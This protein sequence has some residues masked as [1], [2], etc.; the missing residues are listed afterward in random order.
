MN[1]FS[2]NLKLLGTSDCISHKNSSRPSS[3]WMPRNKM[4]LSTEGNYWC[5]RLLTRVAV[6][7][8]KC[9]TLL[10]LGNFHI[11]LADVASFPFEIPWDGRLPA[12]MD[13]GPRILDQPAGKHGH[14]IAK[15]DRLIFEDGVSQRFWGVGLTFSSGTKTL[16]PPDKIV[17]KKIV[18]KLAQ[19]GFNHVRFVGLDGTAP[20]ITDAWLRTGK[21]DSPTLDKLD[22]FIDLLRKEGIYYSFAIN[23]GAVRVLSGVSSIPGK[24]FGPDF[25]R[26]RHVRLL[27]DT[28]IA[29]QV[30]W[31]QAFFS[32]VNPYTGLSYAQDPANLYVS[33]M[34]EDSASLAYFN[35]YDKLGE[36]AK[37]LF[38]LRYRNFLETGLVS[39]RVNKELSEGS[40]SPK[41]LPSPFALR[42]MGETEK[43]RI[44]EFL[45]QTDYFVADK[46]KQG[47]RDVGYRGLFTFNNMWSGYTALL[48]NYKLGDYIETHS[49]F[50]HPKR[51]GNADKV[52][53]RSLISDL[54]PADL[55][56]SKM[57]TDF[58]NPFC[59][60]FQNEVADRPLIV[61]EWNHNAWSDRPYEGP[62]LMA[63]Y[64]AFQGV[65]FLDSH[66]FFVHP[67][68]DPKWQV[69]SEPFAV[70]SNPV[71][72]ALYPSLSLAF[73]KGYLSEG[74]DECRWVEAPSQDVFFDKAVSIGMRNAQMNSSIPLDAGYWYRLRK[75]LISAGPLTPC[76]LSK[77]GSERVKTRTGEIIWSR[78]SVGRANLQLIS[79]RFV[80]IAGDPKLASFDLGAV[81]ISL[82]DQG[83][84]TVVSLDDQPLRKSRKI[85]V[86][87]VSGFENTGWDRSKSQGDYTVSQPGH[88]PVYLKTPR[89]KVTIS[90]DEKAEV[91]IFAVTFAGLLE[92]GQPVQGA[93]NKKMDIS[94]EFGREPS[95]WYL[96]TQ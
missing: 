94:L 4:S 18:Q 20:E 71:W 41:T 56:G 40:K 14:L 10:L 82:D 54:Y 36:E 51:V 76:N 49:Y 21:V 85:L 90:R 66:T 92:V 13:M 59:C 81:K 30:K 46:I 61:T 58:G 34:N 52:S 39:G 78:K 88:A 55:L 11:A 93:G 32:H 3:R 57:A 15:G 1:K 72:M 33:A 38:N 63:A 89:G 83:A 91:K 47:L 73:V 35:Y 70:G 17:A 48:V 79:E 43:R 84:V 5:T 27:D 75:T 77:R 87:A 86:T 28:A 96:I 67:S 80:A 7:F 23:N 37:R 68:P 8:I 22:Y 19:Y 74:V 16:F 31:H 64:S 95:P 24:G 9:M 53:A 25:Q 6:W 65:E 69:P 45:F 44:A 26:Y 60:F 50:D 42:F 2:L 12:E 29:L 62:L